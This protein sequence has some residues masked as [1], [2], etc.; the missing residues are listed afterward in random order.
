M[1]TRRWVEHLELP[2]YGYPFRSLYSEQRYYDSLDTRKEGKG[3]ESD[4]DEYKELT[5]AYSLEKVIIESSLDHVTM[6]DD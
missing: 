1:G 5:F 2:T 6:Q 3:F 4:K